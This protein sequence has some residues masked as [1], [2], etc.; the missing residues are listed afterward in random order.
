MKI[1]EIMKQSLVALTKEVYHEKYLMMALIL[2]NDFYRRKTWGFLMT[3]FCELM[4][5]L[6]KGGREA[7][8]VAPAW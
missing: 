7:D 6:P 2:S 5:T 3:I 8:C 4:D 1:A